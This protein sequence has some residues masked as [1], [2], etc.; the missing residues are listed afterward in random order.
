MDKSG[1]YFRSTHPAT[2]SF[3]TSI[4]RGSDTA[5]RHLVG[6]IRQMRARL[7]MAIICEIYVA[8]S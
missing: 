5:W 2:I 7:T 1:A 8:Q 6:A 3:R 4:S